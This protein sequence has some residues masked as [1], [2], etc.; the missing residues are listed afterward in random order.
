MIHLTVT[1]TSQPLTQTLIRTIRS[2]GMDHIRKSNIR[3]KDVQIEGTW[4]RAWTREESMEIMFGSSVYRAKEG[5]DVKGN[6]PK[7]LRAFRSERLAFS[8]G[9][10]VSDCV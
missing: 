10:K 8:R 3:E 9:K 2:S 6:R 4:T 7:E 1:A 5:K